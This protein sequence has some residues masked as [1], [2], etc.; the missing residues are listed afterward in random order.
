MAT[1]IKH[2]RVVEDPW[3]MLGH[4]DL[5]MDS[6]NQDDLNQ[7]HVL[8]SEAPSYSILPLQAYDGFSQW[9]IKHKM[10]GAWFSAD[11]DPATLTQALLSL[12]LLCIDIEHFNHGQGFSLAPVIKQQLNYQGELRATGNLIPDQLPYLQRCGIDS[13]SLSDEID[14]E[15]ALLALQQAPA[16]SRFQK[17]F[18]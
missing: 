1:L 4:D 2:N 3:R 14:W 7:R 18:Y 11:T 5:N 10:L 15:Y 9:P 13:F 12:P 16:P 6:L 8:I 17:A